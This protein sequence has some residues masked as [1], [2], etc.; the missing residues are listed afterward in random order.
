MEARLIEFSARFSS[1]LEVIPPHY[2]VFKE[3][4]FIQSSKYF[5]KKKKRKMTKEMSNKAKKIRLN[6]KQPKGVEE[7]KREAEEEKEEEQEDDMKMVPD[8]LKLNLER[9]ESVTLSELRERLNKKITECRTKRKGPS[10][11]DPD[12]TNRKEHKV[13]EKKK[14]KKN[15]TK[16]SK[17][18]KTSVSQES[19]TT[20]E[21]DHK[22]ESCPVLFNKFNLT[23]PEEGRAGKK[24]K[25][26]SLKQ[27][28]VKA[29]EREKKLHDVMEEDIDKGQELKKKMKWDQALKKAQGIRVKNDPQ[30]LKKSLKKEVK[31][32]AVSRKNWEE[33]LEK[34]Q[35]HQEK[36]Q[37]QRQ[38]H[39]KERIDAKKTKN[40]SKPNSKSKG[41]K[42]IVVRS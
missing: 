1:T 5:H 10:T 29:E 35:Q 4:E 42:K 14:K 15:D 22:D 24:R 31:R 38:R 37:T 12:G 28:L 3:E 16:H 11:T 7:L 18:D 27:L 6:P 33:R 8:S 13:K 17:K 30:M 19:S 9:I 36:I 39:I 25:K 2:Y 23:D 26:D 41:K 40:S 34:Q 32:K 21:K 20:M